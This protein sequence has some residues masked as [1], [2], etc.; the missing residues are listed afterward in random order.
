MPTF[1]ASDGLWENHPI[2]QV[3]TPEGFR[4]DPELVQRFYDERRA[5]LRQVKPTAAHRALAALEEALGTVWIITQNVD[6]LHERAGSR[7]IIH[8]HGELNRAWC[9]ACSQRHP[10]TATLADRPPCPNC[11]RS[12]L[13]PDIVWFGEDIYGANEIDRVV[14]EA[15][16]FAVIGTSGLVY[17]AAGLAS[18]AAANGAR[19]V[20]LNLEGLEADFDETRIGPASQ[21]VP[22]WVEEILAANPPDS[23]T[24]PRSGARL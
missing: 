20:L 6:D 15:E 4:A 2:E 16:V 1:R 10:W 7:Q 17:P 19:T 23:S 9:T 22:A 13:R 21:L 12:N 8:I 18:W 11:G 5:Q 3:A 14:P 24:N